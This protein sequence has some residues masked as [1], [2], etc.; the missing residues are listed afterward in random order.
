MVETSKNCLSFVSD[1]RLVDRYIKW[2][3]NNHP[4]AILNVDANC[5]DSP[6]RSGFDGI[7][8]N[9]FDDYPAGFSDFIRESSDILLVEMYAIYK[10]LLLAK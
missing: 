5:L 1:D 2:N 3:N 6:I 8:R 7:I 4:C 9:T 10:G